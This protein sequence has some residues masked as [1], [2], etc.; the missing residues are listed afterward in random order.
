MQADNFRIL[1]L[2]DNGTFAEKVCVPATQLADKPAH[3]D[4]RRTPP[5]CRSRA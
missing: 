4:V 1:G 2:P 3:L 5:R